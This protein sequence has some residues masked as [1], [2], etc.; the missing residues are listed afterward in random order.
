MQAPQE[1]QQSSFALLGFSGA[2]ILWHVGFVAV[3]VGLFL[4]GTAQ[5]D[6]LHAPYL[7]LLLVHMAWP[8]LRLIPSPR[9][10]ILPFRQVMKHLMMIAQQS[11]VVLNDDVQYHHESMREMW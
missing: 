7:V 6:L 10:V 9:M 1:E 4:V 2:Q 3:P 11:L 8:A 5:Y